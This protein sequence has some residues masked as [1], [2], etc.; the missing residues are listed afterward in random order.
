MVMLDKR[1]GH[2]N[3]T[4]LRKISGNQLVHGICNIRRDESANCRD[5]QIGKLTRTTHPSQGRINTNMVPKLLNMDL[6]GPF[7]VESIEG[8]RY[9]LVFVD[10]FLIF[11]GLLS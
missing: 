3:L 4:A 5:C 8:K 9:A 1:L 6:M 2:L 7:L 11:L 10:D